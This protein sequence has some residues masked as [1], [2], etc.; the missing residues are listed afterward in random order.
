MRPHIHWLQPSFCPRLDYCDSLLAG[1]PD[2]Q[3]AKLQRIQNSAA[4]LVLRKPRRE[5][6]TP[7]LKILHWLP[8][9]ARIEYKVSTLCYQCLNSVTMPSYLCELLRPYT[10][11]RTLRS[12]GSSLLVVPRFSLNTFGKISFSLFGPATWIFTP[13]TRQTEP[14]SGHVQ[15]TTKDVSVPK[16]PVRENVSVRNTNVAERE[17]GLGGLGGWWRDWGER[18]RDR[19]TGTETERE[20][21]RVHKKLIMYN[22]FITSFK[23]IMFYHILFLLT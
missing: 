20:R 5:S 1:L 3:L 17:R 8:V 16:T 6:A 15:K 22:C 18:Q 7:L 23:F 13:C 9:K 11:Y 10:Q 2:H 4:R 21:E 14:V 19:Q 12:Q